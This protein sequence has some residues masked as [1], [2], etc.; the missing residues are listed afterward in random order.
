VNVAVVGAGYVGLVTG[1][2]F[3][4]LGHTVTLLDIDEDRVASIN[5]G[6]APIFEAHLEPLLKQ[7]VKQGRLR[8]TLTPSEAI[9]SAEIVF[10]AVNTPP[11]PDGEADMQH[12]KSAAFTIGRH[13]SDHHPTVVVTK[14]TVPIGSANAVGLWITD[15]LQSRPHGAETP[16]FAV[17]S[18]PE[19]LREGQA[20]HD[21]F[22]PDRIVWG[23]DQAWADGLLEGLYAPIRDQN[24]A[25]PPG[26]PRPAGFGPVPVLR[27][28]PV[29]VEM[30]KYAANAFLATKISFANEMARLCELVGAD[31]VQV[32]DGIGLDRRIGRAFLNAGV[33]YGGS[34]FGKDLAALIHTAAEYGYRPKL[35]QAT[36][37]VN[38]DQRAW[39]VQKLQQALK[40]LKGRRIAVLGL[41][42]KP[43][44]DDLRDAPAATIIRQ[45]LQREARVVAYD[46][47][48][49]ERA[50]N[51]WGDLDVRYAA[52]PLQAASQ[53]D[54][55]LIVTE[56]ADFA[57][58]NW[59]HIR[60]VMAQPIVVDGR[61]MLDPATMAARGFQYIAVG[62]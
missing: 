58:L 4:Y 21:S 22:Y 35:I 31:V 25:P 17:A 23:T 14:S 46:P 55:L 54:A 61:N 56:W 57:R 19:F 47:V 1:A 48:A 50:R 2:T 59:E 40:T 39:M 10:I 8:A 32:M 53:A 28:D 6:E 5:A 60:K 33:G 13:L 20:L 41:A 11:G 12:V 15:G 27:A 26:L 3:A 24:F 49:T 37:D 36:V 30:I 29:S 62:R 9:S 16:I 45:L 43:G 34:C 7:E 42:F 44:T 38:Q 51:T 18:N 52:D